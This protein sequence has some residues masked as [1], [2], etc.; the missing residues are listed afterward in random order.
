MAIDLG[1]APAMGKG[2]PT[3]PDPSGRFEAIVPLFN[4]EISGPFFW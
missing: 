2:P 3:K 4:L 1:I